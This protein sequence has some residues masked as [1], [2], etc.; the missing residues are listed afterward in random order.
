MGISYI[1]VSRKIKAYVHNKAREEGSM[2]EGYMDKKALP[3]YSRYLDEIETVFNQLH[4][5]NDE[6]DIVPFNEN[7]L[8]PPVGGFTYFTLSVKEKL[9]AC[10]YVLTNCIIVN[11]F[12]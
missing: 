3:F 11:P 6:S 4:R 8:F 1:E 12:L 5:V 2:V 7:T 9:Q 10:R